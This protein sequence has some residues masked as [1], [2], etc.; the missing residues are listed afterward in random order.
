MKFDHRISY[1]AFVAVLAVSGGALAQDVATPAP[2]ALAA[3]DTADDP[4]AGELIVTGTRVTGLK[5]ADSLAPIKLVGSDALARVGQPNLNLALSQLVPSFTTEALGGDTANLTLS[6]RLR[7]LSPNHTLVLVNGKRRHATANLHVL[8]GQFQGGASPDLD[9]IPTAAIER[10]EVLEDGAAAQYGTDA[11]AGVINIILK[12]ANHGLTFSSTAGQYYRSDGETYA[13]SANLGVPLGDNGFLNLTMFHRYHDYT[14]H[15][16]AD[17]RVSHPDGSIRTTLSPAA[18]AADLALAGYPHINHISGDAR[19]RLTDITY[20]AGYD[21]T[22][23]IHLYSFGGWSRRTARAFENFRVP[24]RVVASPVLGTPGVFGA[25]GSIPFSISGF[26]PKEGLVENDYSTGLG[27]KGETG[28]WNWDLSTTYG[29]DEDKIYTLDSANASLFVNTHFTPTDFYDG[30]FIATQWTNNVDVSRDFDIGL[31]SPLNVAAGVE[32]RRDS[33]EIKSGDAASIYLEG[34][35]SYPGF[36]PTDAGKHERTNYG[37]YLDL[38]VNPVEGLKLDVAGRYEHYSDFG[39]TQIG[40]IS[41]RYD[42]SPAFALRSTIGTGFRAPTLAEEFYSATNVGPTT[43][44]VQLPANSAAAKLVGVD[45][46]KPEKSTSFSGGLVAHPMPALSVTLDAYQITIRDR[47]VGSG[48]LYG[49][50]GSSNS[51]AVLDAIAAHGNILDPAVTFQGIQIFLNGM[52]TRTR[53]VDF[54]LS[55]ASEFSFGRV[56][57]SLVANYNKT[58]ILKA[59]A[60]TPAIPDQPLFDQTARSLL[61]D[62]S[63]RWKVGFG[64]LYTSGPL[65]VNLH[66]TVYGPTSAFRSPDGGTYYKT[67]VGVAGITDLELSYKLTSDIEL[68]AGANNLFNK[69]APT[70]GLI[71]G[72]ESMVDGSNVYDAPLGITPYGINGGYYYARLTLKL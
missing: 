42:F 9:L 5:A 46:L 49:L 6:A 58:R 14:D 35:Q 69:T 70:I 50:G 16:G 68:A 57:W 2:T 30:A 27:L 13:A 65:T 54:T 8:G 60:A 36:Q 38:A 11:I 10:I 18:Q 56:D 3:S 41:G 4:A 26:N 39:S 40:K 19:S 37:A 22:P 72:T 32:H 67:K 29:R 44:F 25:P 33:Y 66:E 62:A 47:I 21:I 1:G 53:G 43:A 17:A 31:A 15:G 23:D 28:G 51:Q 61:T 24:D 34:G 64:A 45:N 7:G 71:P 63:P 48:T 59:L 20:N 55:Y 52:K 12:T